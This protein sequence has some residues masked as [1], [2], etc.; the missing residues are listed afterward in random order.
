M[1]SFPVYDRHKPV[2]WNGTPATPRFMGIGIARL[3][4]WLETGR[5]ANRNFEED[6][7]EDD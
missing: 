2:L 5:V 7:H 6:E 4:P 1:P 3:R